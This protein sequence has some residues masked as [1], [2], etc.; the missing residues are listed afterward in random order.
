MIE[1]FNEEL[2]NAKSS[3]YEI[4]NGPWKL[5]FYKELYDCL[6]EVVMTKD[7]II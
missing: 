4:K 2:R 3:K 7:R 5:K 1:A 6:C